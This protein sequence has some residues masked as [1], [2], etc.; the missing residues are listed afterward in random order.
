MRSA[1]WRIGLIGYGE[2][3]KIF[4]A[5]LV[6]Q[7]GV[8]SVGA[9]D[10]KFARPDTAAAERDHAARAGVQAYDSAASLCAASDIVISAVTASNTLAVAAHSDPAES[11]ACTPA[12]AA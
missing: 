5:A 4:A 6:G 1:P 11:Y 8:E 9:W 2:V 3:G 12:R 10:L 7:A